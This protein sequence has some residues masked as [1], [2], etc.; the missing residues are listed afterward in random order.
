[1]GGVGMSANG[2]RGLGSS[3]RSLEKVGLVTLVS[4]AFLY[5]DYRVLLFWFRKTRGR[6]ESRG[7]LFR[8]VEGE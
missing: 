8:V 7:R 6:S 3:L 4:E 5:T 1:M 2:R